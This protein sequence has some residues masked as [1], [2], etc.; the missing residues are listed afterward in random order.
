MQCRDAAWQ[1]KAANEAAL[2]FKEQLKLE[3]DTGTQL[4]S[5]AQIAAEKKLSRDA[6]VAVMEGV[7]EYSVS[8]FLCS[9]NQRS[10]SAPLR[11]LYT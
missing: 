6:K 1:S 10:H 7:V 4:G 9:I 11:A 3:R 2:L 5:A 8:V